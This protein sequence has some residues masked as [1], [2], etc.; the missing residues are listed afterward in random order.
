VDAGSKNSHNPIPTGTMS[1]T[2]LAEGLVILPSQHGAAGQVSAQLLSLSAE[3][4]GVPVEAAESFVQD[5]LDL[6]DSENS[7]SSESAS[8]LQALRNDSGEAVWRLTEKALLHFE[9]CRVQL[10]QEG[11]RIE[12]GQC[13]GS[14]GCVSGGSGEA[15]EP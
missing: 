15:S 8:S 6:L 1:P 14:A 11:A 4:A 9:N 7:S 5:C 2:E 13:R 12:L 10:D 3:Y